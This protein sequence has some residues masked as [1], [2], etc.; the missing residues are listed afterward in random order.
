MN[1]MMMGPLA[2]TAWS[3]PDLFATAMASQGISPNAIGNPAAAGMGLD[4]MDPLAG[5]LTPSM[6]GP[7]APDAAAAP[8]VADPAAAANPMAAMS[9]LAGVKAPAS[10]APIMNAG[11]S[12]AQKA[13]EMAVGQKGS[14]YQSAIAQLLLNQSPGVSPVASLPGLMRGIG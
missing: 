13:P 14:A 9:G 8:A 1:P 11:V 4:S 6:A 7:A 2:M 12:G 10:P 5:F 3:N